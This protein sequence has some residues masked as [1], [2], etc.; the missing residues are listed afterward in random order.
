[1]VCVSQLVYLQY[2]FAL[3]CQIRGDDK[4]FNERTMNNLTIDTSIIRSIVYWNFIILIQHRTEPYSAPIGLSIHSINPFRLKLLHRNSQSIDT[5]TKRIRWLMTNV[6]KNGK[7]NISGEKP[8]SFYEWKL[9][10]SNCSTSTDLFRCCRSVTPN[11]KLYHVATK[12]K[13]KLHIY[14]LWHA[15]AAWNFIENETE[16]EAKTQ[17]I[18]F[19]NS[20]LVLA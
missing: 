16:N 2:R 14:P 5:E 17:R 6:R 4:F 8:C 11:G 9:Y 18:E 3:D 20:H 7:R 12:K 1:M 19:F 10:P 13:K 15:L